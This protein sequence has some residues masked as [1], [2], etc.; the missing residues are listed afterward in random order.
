MGDRRRSGPIHLA[1]VA[2]AVVA[3]AACGS[4]S[5]PGPGTADSALHDDAITVASF[6]FPESEVL[7]E[8][9]GQA[10]ESGGY[11]VHHV[12]RAGP[13]E[14]V[15]PALA[16]GVVEVVP[17]Y[18]GTAVGF[19]SVGAVD[20]STDPDENRGALERTLSGEDLTP[21]APAPAQDRNTVVVTGA[22]ADRLGLHDVS[23]LVDA[24]PRLRFGGPPECPTRPLCLPGLERTYGLRFRRFVPL[25]AGG[26]LTL[27]ALRA[28]LVDVAEL[29]TTDPAIGNGVVALTDDR[30]LQPAENVTPIIHREVLRRWG[31]GPADR[32]DDVSGRLTTDVLRGL[33]AEVASGTRDPA[34]VA[35]RWLAAEGLG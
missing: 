32:L 1:L 10:L 3:V 20:A 28:G 7:A 22:T 34:E 19:L 14:L 8:L 9:Y 35:E 26:P 2:V 11:T 27:E 15:D 21:L 13:R 4:T 17:E 16:R 31:R 33:N 25:D 29:F 18:A 24:A 23:D 12:R 5:L 6:D 30:R